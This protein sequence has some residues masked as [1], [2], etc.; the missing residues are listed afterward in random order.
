[1][2]EDFLENTFTEDFAFRVDTCKTILE[3]YS[4][5]ELKKMQTF[6]LEKIKLLTQNLP[7]AISFM[8]SIYQKFNTLH[9]YT[10]DL[11]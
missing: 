4:V 3:N 8:Q 7:N 6:V 10:R 11:Y 1:M 9:K 2:S 5:E